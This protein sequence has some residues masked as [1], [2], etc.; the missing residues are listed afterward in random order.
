MSVMGGS[1][2]FQYLLLPKQA[3]QF[4]IPSLEYSYFDPS[5]RAYRTASSQPLQ[6][7]VTPGSAV[8]ADQPLPTNGLR[9]LKATLGRSIGT[10]LPL[11]A[12]FWVLMAVP[13]MLVLAAG[14]QRWQDWRLR[15]DPAHARAE[16]ALSL[17]RRRFDG[18]STQ[19]DHVRR[20]H[21]IAPFPRQNV[22]EFRRALGES[23]A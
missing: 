1:A 8:A 18:A 21:V 6:V 3:G 19:H 12:W 23:A 9:P 22:T 5:A 16:S 20:I 2:T 15:A 11:Q 10:P 17:A 13:L 4:T 14:W 7:T